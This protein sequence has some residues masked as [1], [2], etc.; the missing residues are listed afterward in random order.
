MDCGRPFATWVHANEP[1]VLTYA[2]FTRPKAPNEL[3]LFVRYA[4]VA[5]LKGH[6]NAPE[7]V[8]ILYVTYAHCTIV[9]WTTSST[10]ER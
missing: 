7:H 1:G 2:L 4:D 9:A 3:L 10:N 8:A 5:A 6:S